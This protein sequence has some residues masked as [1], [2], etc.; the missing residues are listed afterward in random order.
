[1]MADRTTVPI[2][3]IETRVV[4]KSK[5]F[6]FFVPTLIYGH[7]RW[8]ITERVRFQVQN[9]FLQKFKSLFLLN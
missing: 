2:S 1:M 5:A 8:V 4:Q 7:E 9:D 6:S 3:C